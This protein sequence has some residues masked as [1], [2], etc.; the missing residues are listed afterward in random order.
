M[1][2]L[3]G[4]QSTAEDVLGVQSVAEDI[5]G[6]QVAEDLREDG[7]DHMACRHVR[8]GARGAWMGTIQISR[9]FLGRVVEGRGW[10]GRVSMRISLGVWVMGEG[11]EGAGVGDRGG[12][13]D[14]EGGRCMVAPA[15]RG[16]ADQ[17]AV[18]GI[19]ECDGEKGLEQRCL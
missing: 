19:V 12:G 10:G 14:Q 17:E 16:G 4:V 1:A 6:G 7:H 8:Q 11:E 13:V 9:N 15:L 2:R 5:M 18:G 3:R